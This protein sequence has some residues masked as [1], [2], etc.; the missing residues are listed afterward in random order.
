M[1][2]ARPPRTGTSGAN[3]RAA[4]ARARASP[5]CWTR[6]PRRTRPPRVPLPSAPLRC[7]FHAL[8]VPPAPGQSEL[9]LQ[10]WRACQNTHWG[11]RRGC[12]VP[13][14]LRRACAGEEERS[15]ARGLSASMTLDAL[16]LEYGED[17]R[18]Q[19]RTVACFLSGCC[20]WL[21]PR[22]WLLL[23]VCQSLRP[24]R[25]ARRA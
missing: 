7:G 25:R 23:W 12:V 5:R 24:R 3:P 21:A 22:P 1:P 10:S 9:R 15:G 19:V 16:E 11:T 17:P 14:D 2:S 4:A 13:S 6:P 20:A 18:W 8:S